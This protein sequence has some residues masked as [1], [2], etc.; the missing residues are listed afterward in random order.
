MDI[1]DLLSY[2]STRCILVFFEDTMW[3]FKREPSVSR[4]QWFEKFREYLEVSPL[5]YSNS[6]SSGS[7]PEDIVFA[8]MQFLDNRIKSWLIDCALD[9]IS[10]D[11]EFDLSDVRVTAKRISQA[12]VIPEEDFYDVMSLRT[13]E[14]KAQF[15][16]EHEKLVPQR[17]IYYSKYKTTAIFYSKGDHVVEIFEDD[18]LRLRTP[19]G[20]MYLYDITNFVQERNDLL[21]FLK[22]PRSGALGYFKMMPNGRAEFKF[23][24]GNLVSLK[25]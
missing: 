11:K 8:H 10:S 23:D 25:I 12:L 21:F 6:K 14:I 17:T 7:Y 3:D 24:A 16:Q 15:S 2:N 5:E 4:R 22:N 20:Q 1:R 19:T 13:R 18:T 9:M